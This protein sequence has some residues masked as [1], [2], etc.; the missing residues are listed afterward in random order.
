M[1]RK[2]PNDPL[3]SSIKFLPILLLV[4]LSRSFLRI[5][6]VNGASRNENLSPT[7]KADFLSLITPPYRTL[8]NRS[9]AIARK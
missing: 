5:N 2:F 9:W 6:P 1:D 8:T 7:K 4:R 3:G